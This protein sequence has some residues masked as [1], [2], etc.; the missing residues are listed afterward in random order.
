MIDTYL[1]LIG[2][3]FLGMY[4]GVAG[5]ADTALPGI[6]GHQLTGGALRNGVKAVTAGMGPAAKTGLGMLGEGFTEYAQ[7]KG[8]QYAQ[9]L[10]NPNRDTRGDAS[11]DLNNALGG[12][13]GGGPLIAA[14][15]YADT[16]YRRL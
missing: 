4:G 9:G 5:L 14:G 11:D 16:G 2:I 8:S 15:A 7:G 13:I 6:I 1:L 10:L 12:A 3:V